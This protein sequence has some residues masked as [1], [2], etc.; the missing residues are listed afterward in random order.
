MNKKRINV[1]YGSPAYLH[2]K[3]TGWTEL[4]VKGLWVTMT[5]HYRQANSSDRKKETNR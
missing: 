2:Y 1:P 4:W 3:R 5:T